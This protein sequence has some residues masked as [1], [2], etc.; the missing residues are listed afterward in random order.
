MNNLFEIYVEFN[1]I[2]SNENLTSNIQIAQLNK[3][4]TQ[5]LMRNINK[6]EIP[7]NIQN[8]I[9]IYQSII[10]IEKQKIYVFLHVYNKK[11]N[12]KKMMEYI[13]HIVYF[14]AKFKPQKCSQ[15]LTIHLYLTNYKKK[16]S[17]AKNIKNKKL[18][19]KQTNNAFTTSCSYS[20]T[21]TIYRK[22]EWQKVLIHEI[23]HCYGLDFSANQMLVNYAKNELQKIFKINSTFQFYETICETNANIIFICYSLA[24]SLKN[25]KINLTNEKFIKCFEKL[26]MIELKHCISMTKLIFNYFG[27]N[28]RDLIANK[29]VE[30]Y[31][32]ILN[33]TNNN[34]F[35]YFFLRCIFLF[36]WKGYLELWLSNGNFKFIETRGYINKHLDII[37]FAIRNNNFIE[38]FENVDVSAK[39]NIRMFS[40]DL[41]N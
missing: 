10:E 16:L 32:E 26:I 2:I 18:T 22:E 3:F 33:Q 23:F 4:E 28:F 30:N 8:A 27:I 25:K 13:F 1:N 17:I 7:V 38:E 24:F 29:I 37:K 5:N 40:F 20:T 6:N 15:E 36:E 41:L 31:E 39:K 34:L 35:C 12:H 14:F 21:I 11:D 9:N 19:T